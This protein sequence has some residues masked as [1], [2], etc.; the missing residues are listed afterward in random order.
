MKISLFFKSQALYARNDP[1]P[2]AS[3]ALCKN[4]ASEIIIPTFLFFPF[5]LTS[6]KSYVNNTYSTLMQPLQN[7]Q[8]MNALQEQLLLGLLIHLLNHVEYDDEINLIKSQSAANFHLFQR[9]FH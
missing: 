6:T 3:G 8:S 4:K 7:L 5:A 1:K 2:A 9:Y